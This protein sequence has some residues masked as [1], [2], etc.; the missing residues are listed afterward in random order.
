MRVRVVGL[1]SVAVAVGLALPAVAGAAVSFTSTVY[2]LPVADS[3]YHS[4][5]G[6]V[7]VVDLNNDARRDI[8][9][10][11]GGGN[12]G[13]LF[14]LLGQGAGTFGAPQEYPVCANSDGGTMVTGQ[15]DAAI[16]RCGPN[17]SSTWSGGCMAARVVVRPRC[18]WVHVRSTHASDHR[19]RASRA[20]CGRQWR[21]HRLDCL[22]FD[23]K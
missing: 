14:V 6:A 5:I 10:Y 4:R 12:V 2:P 16:T 17:R 13:R 22:Q 9:V 19:S 1:G 3:E 18:R 11:R 23:H 8:V 21:R 15:F 20:R 7:S